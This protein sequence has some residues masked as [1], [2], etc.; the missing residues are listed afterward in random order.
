LT[1]HYNLPDNPDER[2]NALKA[3]TDDLLNLGEVTG[4][5]GQRHGAARHL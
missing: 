5:G 1:A 3:I 2:T 4:F